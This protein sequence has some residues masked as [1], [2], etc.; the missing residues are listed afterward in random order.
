VAVS[1]PNGAGKSTLFSVLTGFAVPDAG[2]VVF[3]GRQ[4]VSMRPEEI[5]RAGL[6]R[7]FQTSQLFPQ[8]TVRENVMVGALTSSPNL[9]A[10]FVRA[11]RILDDIGLTSL[12]DRL[13]NALSLGDRR[14][15]ELGRALAAGP[16][17]LLLD[18][19]LA[20]LSVQEYE[21]TIELLLEARRSGVT[22]LMT[23]HIMDAIVRMADDVFVLDHGRIICSGTPEE[24][25]NDPHVIAAYLGSELKNAYR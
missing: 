23:E 11:D 24:V 16:S 8:L 2:R 19:I 6:V 12:G 25:Q 20:G 18:E 1:G 17:L 15:L 13:S 21:G 7:T 3:C 22:L 14:R 10:A 9:E 5:C 4:V